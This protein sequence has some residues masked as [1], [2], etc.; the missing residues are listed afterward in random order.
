MKLTVDRA[1][2]GISQPSLS[3]PGRRE[4]IHPADLRY[5]ICRQDFA[6]CPQGENG[7]RVEFRSVPHGQAERTVVSEDPS[8]FGTEATGS[9][10]KSRLFCETAAAML[11]VVTF[12]YSLRIISKRALTTGSVVAL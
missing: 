2:A 8:H 1:D 11:S 9:P 6:Q 5:R 7:E 3:P 4:L 12:R 10:N